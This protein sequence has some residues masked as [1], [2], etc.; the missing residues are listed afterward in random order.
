MV[1]LAYLLAV[2]GAVIALAVITRP[3]P[4]A[5]PAPRV[6]APRPAPVADDE[7][8]AAAVVLARLADRLTA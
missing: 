2:V 7:L 4:V 8:R 5:A 6:P 1:A 3:R